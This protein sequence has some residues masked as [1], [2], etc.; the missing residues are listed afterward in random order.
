MNP[1]LDKINNNYVYPSQPS[2]NSRAY[3]EP[4][5]DRYSRQDMYNERPRQ[6]ERYMQ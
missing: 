2:F 1:N 6:S 3:Q 5:P 4:T